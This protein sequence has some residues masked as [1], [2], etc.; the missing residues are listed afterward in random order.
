VRGTSLQTITF[1]S[2]KGG[3]GRTLVVAN[4]A[5]YLARF[6]QKV[7]AIDFDLEAPGLH[8]KFGLGGKIQGGLLDYIYD[9]VNLGDVADK[10]SPRVVE[11]DTGELTGSIHLLPAGAA[12][13][14]DYWRKLA[15]VNW[16]E[17]FYSEDAE[18]IPFFLEL[19]EKIVSEFQPD[20]ILIDS[21]T[22][23][24]EVGGVA[25]T[26]LA[27]QVVC[28]LIYNQ[29]NLDGVREVMRSVR[30]APRLPGQAPVELVPV[31]T[32]VPEQD[33]QKESR[34]GL[35]VRNF[36][37]EEAADLTA[38]LAVPEVVVLHSDPELQL[39]E[40]L[41]IGGEKRLEDSTLLRDYLELF[42]R[43]IPARIIESYIEPLLRQA[44]ENEAKDP[45][46]ARKDIEALVQYSY[47]PEICRE[48]LRF[49]RTEYKGKLGAVV[50]YLRHFL[51]VSDERMKSDFIPLGVEAA[52]GQYS[53]PS[54]NKGF[55][56]E[57]LYADFLG[58]LDRSRQKRRVR[59]VHS[60]V[61]RRD[62]SQSGWGLV[63]SDTSRTDEI[64][65]ALRPLLDLRRRV[66]G[67]R[68]KEYLWRFNETCLQFLETWS[69]SWSGFT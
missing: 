58:R 5:R 1:Y 41:R 52:S 6:G 48:L 19:K 10:I 27:D 25:T 56:R 61:D 32:R 28:L 3:V 60:G 12:P 65:A 59:E 44:V 68:Y 13:F 62:L 37:N 43:L 35:E 17:L 66:A 42:A 54:F 31:L 39:N 20:Y 18:G 15:H 47:H 16:H 23:I 45:D 30:R 50:S 49:Y 38:T 4:V 14:A 2:Y 64:R 69:R 55:N 8:Y 7:F 57:D 36:L 21:R 51:P 40:A 11:V 34:I 24:T 63:F 29:E 26:L 46:G 67:S 33:E 22:G 9:F 53:F